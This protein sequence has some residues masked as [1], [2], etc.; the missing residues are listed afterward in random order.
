MGRYVVRRLLVA[1]PLLLAISVILYFIMRAMPGGPEAVYGQNPHM[2]S[3][4]IARLKELMGLN[5]P[6]YIA[7]LKWLGQC[8]TGNLGNSLFTG[9]PVTEM[10]FER[11]PNT[12]LLMGA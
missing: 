3:E 8:I 4:D 9:R 12:V 1:I 11:I 6:V 10:L 7:Y 5:D 2:R